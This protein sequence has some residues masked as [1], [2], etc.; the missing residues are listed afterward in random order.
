M[1]A[2][3]ARASVLGPEAS[4]AQLAGL[5]ALGLSH[6]VVTDRLSGAALFGND[7]A[8]LTAGASRVLTPLLAPLRQPGAVAVING[9]TSTTGNERTNLRLSDARAAAVAAWLEAR[10]IPASSLDV[11]GHGATD[12]VAAGPSAANRRVVVIIEEPAVPQPPRPSSSAG[13]HA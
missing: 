7:S 8:R 4:R 1:A 12:L 2:G 11:V 9:F 6:R 13:G 3:A 5:V 10:N